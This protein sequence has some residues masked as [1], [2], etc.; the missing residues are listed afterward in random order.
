MNKV[1]KK[2]VKRIHNLLDTLVI[3]EPFNAEEFKQIKNQIDTYGIGNKSVIPM[4]EEIWYYTYEAKDRSE[5]LIELGEEL[6]VA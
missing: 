1:E 4:F 5:T 6:G 2:A 3:K